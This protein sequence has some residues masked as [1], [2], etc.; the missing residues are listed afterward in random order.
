MVD[1]PVARR[2]K[3][4]GR[5][6]IVYAR[7]G[8]SVIEMVSV[9]V[10]MGIMGTLA[11]K[12]VSTAVVSASRRSARREAA[13]YLFR[14]QAVSVQQ[15]RATQLVRTGNVLKILV[16][17]SGTLVQLGRPLDLNKSFG[18]TL[19]GEL[20]TDSIVYFDSRGFA[21]SK[22]PKIII[23]RTGSKDTVCV[24]GLGRVT[25]AGC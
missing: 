3:R 11:R 6:G 23:T 10:L 13:M 21:S 9:L 17:S 8:F 20:S 5:R 19:S 18:V 15:N 12:P 4:V 7:L 14:A 16:D 24:T 2:G 1:R 22:R 25:T